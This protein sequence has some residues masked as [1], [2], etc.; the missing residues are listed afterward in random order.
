MDHSDP[1]PQFS[2]F[3]L[4]I[5]R[6][7]WKSCL[8]RRIAEEDCP[9]SIL[10]G[11]HSRQSCWPRKTTYK[12]AQVPLLASVCR[13]AREVV[14]HWGSY[15]R[16]Q[17]MTSLS[18]I[19]LQPKI[20][21]ALHIN[22]TRDR[23]DFF[24]AEYN[25]LYTPF[26]DT[27]VFM[28]VYRA[29]VQKLPASLVGDFFYPLNVGDYIDIPSSSSSSSAS[30]N[31][32]SLVTDTPTMPL[33]AGFLTDERG[34]DLRNIID[35]FCSCT[36][37]VTVVAISL[38][39]DRMGALNSGLFGLQADAPV[40]TVNYDDM[41]HLCQFYELFKSQSQLE[42]V[43]PDVKRL[44]GFII[45]PEFCA[46]VLSWQKSVKWL[47]QAVRWNDMQLREGCKIF[48]NADP[49]ELWVPPIPREESYLR[50]NT[51]MP[52]EEHWWWKEQAR[53]PTL[54]PQV[55]FRFCESRCF[56]EDQRPE[57]FGDLGI[58]NQTYHKKINERG[59]MVPDE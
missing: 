3:P 1:F 52:N 59:W 24:W 58:S 23:G 30:S 39:I 28:L 34:E 31:S 8:P 2:Q 27:T 41:P 56:E 45:G 54:V 42:E 40:Q 9:Y 13:E 38:H 11:K 55:M 15:Q 6:L 17:D 44:F 26:D 12:N 33:G 32:A 4:E 57:N 50:M 10:D 36:I 16:S 7:I 22:W 21:T 18:W 46:A 53:L 47:M 37:N 19:W 35:V 14:F 49:R 20:D 29:S 51:F 48:G 43:E 25:G 5:R